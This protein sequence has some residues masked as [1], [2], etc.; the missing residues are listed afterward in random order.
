M[1]TKLAKCLINLICIISGVVVLAFSVY[2]YDYLMELFE[3]Q[4][5]SHYLLYKN[6]EPGNV[7]N[8]KKKKKKCSFPLPQ[9]GDGTNLP[10]RIP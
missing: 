4:Y 7:I 2:N 8:S 3:R 5:F 10:L 6:Q 9:P 1:N